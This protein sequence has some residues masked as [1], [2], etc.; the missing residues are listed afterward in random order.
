MRDHAPHPF[1]F[2]RPYVP[3]PEWMRRSTYD[4]KLGEIVAAEEVVEAY[5]LMFDR[6]L[7]QLLGR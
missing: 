4:R 3:K 7:D 1:R 6:K 5:T 2:P